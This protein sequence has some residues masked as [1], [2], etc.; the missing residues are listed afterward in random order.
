MRAGCGGYWEVSNGALITEALNDLD[1]SKN[2]MSSWELTFSS[3]TEM[4][5]MKN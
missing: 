2:M 3:E 1:L 5:F 4:I